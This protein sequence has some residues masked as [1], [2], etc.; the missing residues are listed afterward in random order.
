MFEAIRNLSVVK[1]DPAASPEEVLLAEERLRAAIASGREASEATR[2]S[3]LYW[4]TAEYGLV[5]PLDAP[6]LYGA[7]LLSSI[8]E[9]VHCLGPTWSGCRSPARAPTSPTTS[10]G[11]SPGSSWRGTSITCSRCSTSCRDAVVRARRRPRPRRGAPRA[12]R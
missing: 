11:C 10:P 3:R 2:A 8:G 4:W 7:G 9:A 6:R 12:A 5:G 1:E